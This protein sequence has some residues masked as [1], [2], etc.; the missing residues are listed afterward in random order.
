MNAPKTLFSASSALTL[1][2]V[3]AIVRQHTELSPARR[4]E[5]E[6]ALQDVARAIGVPAETLEASPWQLRLKLEKLHVSQVGMS[7]TRW[8]TVRASLHAA[9]R[10]AGLGS[11]PRRSL[12]QLSSAWGDLLSMAEDRYDRTKL[13]RFARYC[14]GKAIAP[15]AVDD[16]VMAE[17]GRVLVEES[18]VPR[19]PQVHRDA[20]LT[21][22][23]CAD[24]IGTWPNVHLVV[25]CYRKNLS[26][27][28]ADLPG[29]FGADL[30]AYLARRF[31]G[32]LLAD[33]DVPSAKPMTVRNERTLLL[34]LAT[35][36]QEAG[37]D[38]QALLDLRG[39]VAAGN[40]RKALNV[41]FARHEKR[42]NGQTD[43]L[44]RCALRVAR[45]WVKAPAA[46]IEVLRN[47]ARKVRPARG[48]T[49]KN[50][51]RLGQLA[52]PQNAVRMLQLPYDLVAFARAMPAGK[53]A[54]LL[55]QNAL[56]I[57]ILIVAPMRVMNLAN[58][59]LERHVTRTRAGSKGPVHIVIPAHEVKNEVDLEFPLPSDVVQILDLYL[60]EFRPLLV[61]GHTPWLF[62]NTSGGAKTPRQLSAQIP[63]AI[64]DACGLEVNC[65]LF[66][67]FAALLYLKRHPGDYETVRLLLG[68]KSIQTTIQSYCWIER[69][70]AFERYDALL[71]TLRQEF[72]P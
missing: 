39:L 32:D 63:Q 5:I 37:G 44:A 46:E 30:D 22:N 51:H 8:R 6:M 3:A 21:W 60:R 2:D 47:L 19:A 61:E 10:L 65:H 18:L 72:E 38:L 31:E 64:H 11:I 4:Q 71:T 25:P 12:V 58:L 45:H 16:A 69:S 27:A 24:A 52:D 20:V 48:M 42:R 43:N 49:D 54:A 57:A 17:F 9:L 35:L 53:D 40:V 34:Q 66:R 15:E 41:S 70:E 13:S 7:A 29:S 67:H 36:Y 1:A 68:H 56:A 23:K 50:K 59:H 26:V 28:A 55:M 33:D 62:P 14:E